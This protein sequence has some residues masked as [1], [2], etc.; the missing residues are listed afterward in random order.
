MET[1]ADT[2]AITIKNTKAPTRSSSAA[3]GISVRVTGP[4]VCIWLT[5]DSDGAGAVAS[6]MPPKI[7]AR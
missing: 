6:A 1:W 7:K 2:K 5:I 3:M 4:E